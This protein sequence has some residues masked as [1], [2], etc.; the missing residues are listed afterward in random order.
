MAEVPVTKGPLNWQ[1]LPASVTGLEVWEDFWATGELGDLGPA[2]GNLEG[3]PKGKSRDSGSR[4]S[5]PRPPAAWPGAPGL[6]PAWT[7]HSSH[8]LPLESPR[9]H[10]EDSGLAPHAAC[11]PPQV[12]AIDLDEGLN[13]L[14]SYRMQVGMPRMDFLINSSSGVVVTTAELDRERIAEYQ[15]RVVASDA[16]T[17]TKSSTSTLTIHGEGQ[18]ACCGGPGGHQV[19]WEPYSPR[20]PLAMGTLLACLCHAKGASKACPFLATAIRSPHPSWPLIQE[21]QGGLSRPWGPRGRSRRE[22]LQ[23]EPL[24]SGRAV[25][26]EK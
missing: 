17:P 2:A 12:V 25:S 11:L 6:Q 22:R 18:A 20:C 23:R 13:G 9:R 21:T 14:V 24:V 15:L 3:L 5:L 19:G 8:K 16:G 10:T 26:L 4:K 7:P 1:L